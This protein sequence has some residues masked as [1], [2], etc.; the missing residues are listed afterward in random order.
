MISIILVNYNRF[1]LTLNCIA[2]IYSHS[3][4]ETFEIIV[5]DNNSLFGNS[6]EIEEKFPEV[7]WIINNKNMGFA[8]ANNQ[9]LKIAKG[10]FIL[11]LNN[12]TLFV[13]DTLS[14]VL[15]Y[16]KSLNKPALIGCK[17][18]N[19]DGSF[20]VSIADFDNLLNLFGEN[21]FLYK[22]FPK[23]KRLNRFVENFI[24]LN[25]PKKVDIIKGA[26]IF[27]EKKYFDM[28][29]GFD[30]RFYFYSEESDFCK[31]FKDNYGDV[32]YFPNTKIIH[33]GGATTEAIP[34]FSL[35]NLSIGKIQYFQKHFKGLYF[36][37]AVFIHFFGILIRVPIFF[38]N[39]IIKLNKNEIRRAWLYFRLLFV[40]PQN[41]FTKK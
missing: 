21:S 38:I 17:L 30:T 14:I 23:S 32:I 19:E 24:N 11:L 15:N 39:G 9:G 34:W 13:E 20:Q 25:E 28:L 22:I 37:S 36:L 1:D 2:S 16:Y 12:D 29:E 8:Y 7:R 26:F 41:K 33:L 40:Y 5:V 31:R 27:G 3:A 35:K 6:T 4:I 18:L 10:E